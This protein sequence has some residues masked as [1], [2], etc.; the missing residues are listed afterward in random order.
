MSEVEN[1]KVLLVGVETPQDKAFEYSMEELENL[2]YA[3]G[4]EPIKQIVQKLESM[5]KHYYVGKGK[6]EEIAEAA[7][8]IDVVIFNDELSPSQLRNIDE[9]IPCVVMDRTMLILDIFARRAQT[10]EAKLQVEISMLQYQLPRLVGT[11]ENLNR[12]GGSAGF[13]N[14]GGGETKLELDRRQLE[15]KIHKK[16]QELKK[17]VQER[18]TQ[19]EKRK[20]TGIKTVALVG[21]TNAGKS[22]LMNALVADDEKMVFA[23]DI[24]FATLETRVRKVKL[25]DQE[26]CLLTDTVGFV[27]K[28]PHYLIQAF[29]STLEEVKEADVLLHVIDLNNPYYQEQKNIAIRTLKEIGIEDIPI[30]EVYNKIDLQGV[31]ASAGDHK[32]YVSSLQ[33]RGLELL[34]KALREALFADYQIGEFL[35]P[36]AMGDVVSYLNE[37]YKVVD[38]E[39]H[40]SGI[41]LKLFAPMSIFQKYKQYKRVL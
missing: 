6:L 29:R 39:Y 18:K 23:E 8:D 32:V 1:E 24:L 30:I 9:I 27:D 3:C 35:F 40:G 41:A 25:S 13:Y 2:A 38:M 10:K 5:Q 14:R 11:Y 20:Q 4:F 21:Y 17:M 37:Q 16:R 33:E 15:A 19:R 34:R 28:L 31:E 7:E 12:Q 36:Y 22:T 26:E